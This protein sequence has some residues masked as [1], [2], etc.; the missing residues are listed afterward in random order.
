MSGQLLRDAVIAELQQS[1]TVH[2]GYL[3]ART[4]DTLDQMR[5]NQ[6]VVRGLKLAID[7]IE[8]RARNL[9]G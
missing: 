6:G 4:A 9:H 8:N 7:I 2:E 5:L 1:V 3:S